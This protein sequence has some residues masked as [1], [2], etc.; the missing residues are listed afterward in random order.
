[1][2]KTSNPASLNVHAS[3]SMI[4]CYIY[5]CIY[6]YIYT[7]AGPWLMNICWHNCTT[8]CCFIAQSL[9][10]RS[11]EVYQH[12][13]NIS[14]LSTFPLSSIL[15]FY[16]Q[17]SFAIVAMV[18]HLLEPTELNICWIRWLMTV[19]F[20]CAVA[21]LIFLSYQCQTY[22]WWSDMLHSAHIIQDQYV[23]LQDSASSFHWL[24]SSIFSVWLV[25]PH[26]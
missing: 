3:S 22:C 24:S 26:P 17:V 12:F 5:V 16:P 11:L 6:A 1:M 7:V 4:T 15:A 8:T 14:S 23:L 19:L 13:L 2:F 18:V 21:P 25:V 20:N 9:Q 10:F